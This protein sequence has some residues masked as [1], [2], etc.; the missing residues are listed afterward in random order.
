MPRTIIH[1]RAGAPRP[2]GDKEQEVTA[3]GPPAAKD[4]YP[5]KLVKYV[6][7]EVLAFFVPIAAQVGD[8]KGLLWLCLVVGLGGTVGYL[9]LLARQAKEVERPYPYFYV[10]AALAFLGWAIG[11]NEHVAALIGLSQAVGSVV[12]SLCVFIIP[13]LD[14]ILSYLPRKGGPAESKRLERLRLRE[15]HASP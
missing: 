7:A 10:L 8:R 14:N 9:W 4:S 15:T 3:E 12:L 11:T 1:A 13:L 6:P 5:A 2:A